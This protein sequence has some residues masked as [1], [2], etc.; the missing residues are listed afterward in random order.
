M[1]SRE[2]IVSNLESAYREAFARAK[3][4]DDREEMARLDFQF[5]R[6]QIRLEV[7]LD[8]RELLGTRPSPEVAD[9]PRERTLLEEGSSLIEKA[10]VLRKI[11]RLR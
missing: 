9:P 10:H 2:R 8:I 7:L 3:E 6:D 4:K 11:T 1:R 5:Q